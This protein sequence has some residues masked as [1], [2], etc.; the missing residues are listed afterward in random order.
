M[1]QVEELLDD[2]YNLRIRITLSDAIDFFQS[3][4]KLKGGKVLLTD[5]INYK[6]YRIMDLIGRF[7]IAKEISQFKE[8]NMASELYTLLQN[9]TQYNN[10]MSHQSSEMSY[11]IAGKVDSRTS[12]SDNRESIDT[13]RK[14][15]FSFDFDRIRQSISESEKGIVLDELKRL[16]S[17]IANTNPSDRQNAKLKEQI[18]RLVEKINVLHNA[19]RHANSND[20]ASAS[21]DDPKNTL[22]TA[23][24]SQGGGG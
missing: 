7:D 5:F 15:Q 6:T 22:R 17:I 18:E 20:S 11:L 13:E 12:P 24:K 8:K 23:S 14:R 21:R 9:E 10:I 16:C 2:C 1:K 19:V 3:H 4:N